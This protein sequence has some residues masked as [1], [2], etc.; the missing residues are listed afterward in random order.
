T[1]AARHAERRGV[2]G[3]IEAEEIREA[4]AA[5]ARVDADAERARLLAIWR[6]GRDRDRGIA[7]L[8][9][10][11]T[12]PVTARAVEA[13]LPGVEP[14]QSNQFAVDPMPGAA[15]FGTD[16]ARAERERIRRILAL[17]EARGRFA[18]AV[19]LALEGGGDLTAEMAASLLAGM[20]MEAPRQTGAEILAARA[21][22]MT[23]FGADM[24]PRQTA[25]EAT[26]EGWRRA[27]AAANASIGAGPAVSAGGPVVLDLAGPGD[28]SFGTQ[29]DLDRALA[30]AKA[31]VGRT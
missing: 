18:A 25:K 28:P 26:R 31:G 16:A 7:A 8:R 15:A 19:V 2:L 4:E 11:L 3:E 14:D 12:A 1:G 5:A 30:A 22:G 27:V 20:P 17:P 9:M 29:A 13:L 21:A 6:T 23:E 24:Q 10:G